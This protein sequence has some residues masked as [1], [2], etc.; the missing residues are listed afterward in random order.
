MLNICLICCFTSSFISEFYLLYF[1]F[2]L[3]MYINLTVLTSYLFVTF[4]L[5]IFQEIITRGVMHQSKR[6]ELECKCKILS[7]LQIF[8]NF[9]FIVIDLFVCFLL[10]HFL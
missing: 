7:I 5:T 3:L 9:K 10:Y 1:H 2:G 4:S 6:N 8:K